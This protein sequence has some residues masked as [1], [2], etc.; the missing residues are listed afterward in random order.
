MI[1][2]MKFPFGVSYQSIGRWAVVDVEQQ[3]SRSCL[4]SC[5]FH[6]GKNIWRH[7]LKEQ[8][9]SIVHIS[10]FLQCLFLFSVMFIGKNAI[11]YINYILSLNKYVGKSC[12][13]HFMPGGSSTELAL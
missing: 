4:S 7:N 12:G 1:N 9:L 10:L 11:L 13:C 8:I 6:R 5:Y 2:E 3:D